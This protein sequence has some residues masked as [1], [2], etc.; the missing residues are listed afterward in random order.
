M[1]LYSDSLVFLIF[2]AIAL[3]GF[4]LIYEV[5]SLS[6][7]GC[8]SKNLKGS[9]FCQNCGNN[10][11]IQPN[12]YPNIIFNRSAIILSFFIPPIALY[13]WFY[14]KDIYPD[15][16]KNVNII[17]FIGFIVILFNLINN[18]YFDYGYIFY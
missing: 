1:V 10:V 6:C 7:M 16:V 13:F 14:F 9:T 4:Y 5:L 15:K 8:Q 12:Y 11:T 3:F 18:S 2:G 17:A